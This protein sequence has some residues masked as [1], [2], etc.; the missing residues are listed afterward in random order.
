MRE[1]RGSCGFLD[2]DFDARSSIDSGSFHDPASSVTRFVVVNLAL[3]VA[4][5]AIQR[6]RMLQRV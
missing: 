3:T 6:V 2:R 1:A 5:V 4:V